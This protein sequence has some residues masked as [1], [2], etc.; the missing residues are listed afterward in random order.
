MRRSGGARSLMRDVRRHYLVAWSF[1]HMYLAE[2]D[3][4]VLR[5][6]VNSSSEVSWIEKLAETDLT[7]TWR[8]VPQLQG[9]VHPRYA[10]WHRSSGQI[11]IPSGD[12]AKPDQLVSDPDAGWTQILAA[13][14][15]QTPWFGANPAPFHLSISSRVVGRTLYR[16]EFTWAADHFKAIGMAA[17]PGAKRWWQL[18]RR[19]VRR[20]SEVIPWPIGSSSRQTAFLFPGAA[21][22]VA[23]GILLDSNPSNHRAA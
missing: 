9:L 5:D 11:N 6:F 2:S 16:S 12:V 15:Q 7:Y 10:L 8:T 18:L 22:L 14:H 23:R 19:H 1:I 4:A 20:N 17:A 3:S 13:P 21:Q